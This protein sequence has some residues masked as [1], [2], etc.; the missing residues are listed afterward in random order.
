MTHLTE[1]ELRA[2]TNGR[3]VRQQIAA[4]VRLGIP[5]RFGGGVV[6]VSRDVAAK[7][8]PEV[9]GM[10]LR[11]MR[12]RAAQLSGSLEDASRLLQH[13]STA[14]TRRHY[15]GGDRVRPVR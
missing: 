13:S 12:K 5:F 11:D 2:L 8:C 4:L 15:R 3:T 7:D 14:V 10:Y 1:A 9:A 6:E